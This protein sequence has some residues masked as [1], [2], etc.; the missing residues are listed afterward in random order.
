M[1]AFSIRVSYLSHY[2]AQQKSFTQNLP[3]NI[4]LEVL[5]LPLASY[6]TPA[7]S[8]WLHFTTLA[9][10]QF[11]AAPLTLISNCKGTTLQKIAYTSCW[12]KDKAHSTH[13]AREWERAVN[14]RDSERERAREHINMS[15]WLDNVPNDAFAQRW[16]NL[17]IMPANQTFNRCRLQ[18]PLCLVPC[19]LLLVSAVIRPS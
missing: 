11:W 1:C 19:P 8:T 2:D 3:K 17:Q 15:K 16:R 10:G 14:E 13:Q 5:P 18:R 4:W 7:H 9:L 6:F 12:T